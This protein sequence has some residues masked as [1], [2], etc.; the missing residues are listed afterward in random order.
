[1]NPEVPQEEQCERP[2]NPDT[3]VL[4]DKALETA[5]KDGYVDFC[6][7]KFVSTDIKEVPQYALKDGEKVIF[8]WVG[9]NLPDDV[10]NSAL[11]GKKRQK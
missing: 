6:I 11:V 10:E 9:R 8:E 7:K 2:N 5:K 3:A 4:F 1:M